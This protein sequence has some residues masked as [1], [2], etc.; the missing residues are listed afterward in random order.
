MKVTAATVALAGFWL[1][2]RVVAIF[3]IREASNDVPLYF[4]I[5]ART[6]E[7]GSPLL[8]YPPGILVAVVPPFLFA[9]DVGSYPYAF[10]AWML[11]WDALLVFLVAALAR[12][13]SPDRETAA[14]RSL[15]A[16]AAYT[17]LVALLGELPFQRYDLTVAA[18]VVAALLVAARG[19]HPAASCALLAVGTWMK[20]FP[21][22]LVPL[23][24][25]L[26][27]TRVLSAGAQPPPA[28]E[29]P[30]QLGRW[31]GRR[32]LPAVAALAVVCVALWAPFAMHP[33]AQPLSL[34][35]FHATRGV[36]IES[37]AA[38]VLLFA[39]HFLGAPLSLEFAF[40]AIEARASGTV[41]AA[42][43]APYVTAG[44]I[45]TATAMCARRAY[46]ERALA[47]TG[48]AVLLVRG[49]ALFLCALIIGGKVGSPQFL[50]WLAPILACVCVLPSRSRA[51]TPLC[52]AAFMTTGFFL[53]H[54][55]PPALADDAVGAMIIVVRNLVL[56]VL[57]VVLLRER[58]HGLRASSQTFARAWTLA[59]PALLLGFVAVFSMHEVAS[60]DFW[61]HQRVGLDIVASGTV[62]GRD[63]YSCTALGAPYVVHGWL[64]A[65]L[66]GAV[67]KLA[68]AAG[69]VALRFGCIAAVLGALVLSLPRRLRGLPLPGLNA[70][71]R[72]AWLVPLLAFLALAALGQRLEDRPHLLA[73]VPTAALALAL[74][75]FSRSGRAR[76]I[77]WLPF[78][79]V[80]WTNLHGSAL[81]APALLFALATAELVFPA[82]RARVFGLLPRDALVLAGVGALCL[83]ASAINPYGLELF[84][85]S[86]GLFF[87]S[88]YIKQFIGEWSS[89]LATYQPGGATA[90]HWLILGIFWLQL[91]L[92]WRS[93]T[94]ARELVLGAVATYFSLTW[95]RFLADAVVL[96]FPSFALGVAVI[97][98]ATMP[99][100]A[101]RPQWE[102]TLGVALAV[103]AIIAR[104]PELGVRYA[105]ALP[106]EE[107]A[108]LRQEGLR[109]C[110]FVDYEDGGFVLAQLA[111]ELRPVIDGRIDVY[112]EQRLR[113]YIDAHD[114]RRSLEAYLDRHEC[115]AALLRREPQNRA[116][117]AALASSNEWRLASDGARRAL[118]IRVRTIEE[119][120]P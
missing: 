92:R 30:R 73:L 81:L 35:T 24:L 37:V 114:D 2:L 107:V 4:D 52:V 40:G 119:P 56:V 36:Q 55:Q 59:R 16:V 117:Y 86:G 108:M 95:S 77:V 51:T 89:S 87:G 57:F 68:G 27:L 106:F 96:L 105:P 5:A 43:V 116:A 104:A 41:A 66:L 33:Q 60:S 26:D 64:G 49:A 28:G 93:P 20:V 19:A 69:V 12:A 82:R 21:V 47:A 83:M 10:A 109:G 42:A 25:G 78:V 23:V 34:F 38:S 9:P 111:P 94:L 70:V 101:I 90:A 65:V 102:A 67:D 76:E 48:A 88:A 54:A 98:R 85:F 44:L 13:T 45:L 39:H 1:L 11:C 112:G 46:R 91:A 63:S 18:L 53:A 118:F 120:G 3:P 31:L 79:V 113:E 62:P 61:F 100:V 84:R 14:M 103:F 58:A 71:P 75:R 22:A 6:L 7:G 8:E 32:A 80:V 110:V 97:A 17:G 50:V 29:L 72:G 99:R 15:G 115:V 74:A